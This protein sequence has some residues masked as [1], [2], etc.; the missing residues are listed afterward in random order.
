MT[1][2]DTYNWTAVRWTA[3]VNP[4]RVSKLLK[5][6]SQTL[7][8][9]CFANAAEFGRS[10]TTPLRGVR[11]RC[12][13][14]SYNLCFFSARQRLE[15]P[16]TRAVLIQSFD[17]ALGKSPAPIDHRWTGALQFFRQRV[18]GS[19]VGRTT[20]IGAHNTIRCSVFPERTTCSNSRLFSEVSV[21]AALADHMHSCN[22]SALGMSRTGPPIPTTDAGFDAIQ[23]TRET[24]HGEW[25]YVIS[26]GRP[27]CRWG[28]LNHWLTLGSVVCAMEDVR[29]EHRWSL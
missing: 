19:A 7:G 14:T 25:N 23:L 9:G 3:I 18:L 5:L 6:S 24:F 26:P 20:I 1:S 27:K 13:S 4:I 8:V 21:N 11:R 28:Q 29:L 17:S 22:D 16:S 15:T 12:L 10:S 2:Y